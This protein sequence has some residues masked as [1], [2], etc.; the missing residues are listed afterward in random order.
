[1][2]S[3]KTDVY[4]LNSQEK[5]GNTFLCHRRKA[6]KMT[7]KDQYCNHCRNDTPVIKVVNILTLRSPYLSFGTESI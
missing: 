5:R 7:K 4:N 6:E 1:M 3:P 2:H